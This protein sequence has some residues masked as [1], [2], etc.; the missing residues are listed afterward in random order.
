MIATSLRRTLS[1]VAVSLVATLLPVA[2]IVSGLMF[3]TVLRFGTIGS[4]IAALRGETLIVQPAS[5]W[6]GVVR[7]GQKVA[8]TYALT[9]LSSRPTRLLGSRVSCTCTA[10]DRLPM[11]LGPRETRVFHVMFTAPNWEPTNSEEAEFRDELVVYTSDPSHPQIRLS[12]AGK[13]AIG[14]PISG[15]SMAAS[16]RPLSLDGPMTKTTPKREDS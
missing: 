14:P 13:M 5:Q 15:P 3:A 10:P 6:I 4:A 12:L 16:P 11:T 1:D 7:P 8:L 2:L 9:N